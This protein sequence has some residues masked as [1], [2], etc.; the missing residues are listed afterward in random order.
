MLCTFFGCN[1]AHVCIHDPVPRLYHCA[2]WA[3][4][5]LP[6]IY[7]YTYISKYGG[8]IHVVTTSFLQWGIDSSNAHTGLNQHAIQNCLEPARKGLFVIL[9]AFELHTRFVMKWVFPCEL[10]RKPIPCQYTNAVSK[11]SWRPLRSDHKIRS[12]NCPI[13]HFVYQPESA[14]CAVLPL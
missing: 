9:S 11:V 8:C 1:I 5:A 13:I 2:C 4:D 14:Q 3:Y 10:K 7:I 12:D 6:H